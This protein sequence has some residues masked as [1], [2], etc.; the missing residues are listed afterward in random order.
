VTEHVA[1]ESRLVF[2]LPFVM[3]DNRAPRVVDQA[4]RSVQ[5]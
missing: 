5:T 1:A 3:T 4:L 2:A